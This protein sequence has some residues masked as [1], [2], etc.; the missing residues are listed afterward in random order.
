M[1]PS[2]HPAAPECRS[3]AARAKDRWSQFP[4]IPAPDRCVWP[5]G[6]SERCPEFENW[7]GPARDR[8]PLP[9]SPI[10][11]TPRPAAPRLPLPLAV[12]CCH[13]TSELPPARPGPLLRFPGTAPYPNTHFPPATWWPVVGFGRSLLRRSR[14]SWLPAG[15]VGSISSRTRSA[16]VD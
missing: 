4:L 2:A 3:P 8:A 11:Q 1:P 10:A 12:C 5:I 16:V 6:S 14:Y 7:S 15:S 13:T 9:P